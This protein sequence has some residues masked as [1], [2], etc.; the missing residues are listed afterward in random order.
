MEGTKRKSNN[1]LIQGSILAIA[2][3]ISRLIGMV[4]RIPLNNLIENE[5]VGIYSLAFKIYNMCLILSCYSIPTAVSRLVAAKLE[6]KEHKNAYRV[7]VCAMIFSVAVGFVMALILFFGADFFAQTVVKNPKCAM[8]IRVLAPNIVIFSIM[9]VLRG[10]F[11]G[12]NTM[13]PTSISQIVEQIV[14]AVVSIVAAYCYMMAHSASVDIAAYGAKGGTLGTV[15][16]SLTGMLFLLF[17]LTIYFPTMK[18]QMRRDKTVQVDSSVD[19]FKMIVITIIPIVLSQAV[20]Q[21]SGFLDTVFFHSILAKKG[22]SDALRNTYVGIYSN[23]YELLTNVPIA[24]ATAIGAA[25]VPTLVAAL[26]R[27]DYKEIKRKIHATIKFNMIVAIPSAVGLGVLAKPLITMLFNDKSMDDIN[28]ATM[29]LQVGSIAVVL[30]AL[31]TTTNAI[32]NSLNKLRIPLYHS[33]IALVAH[34]IVVIALLQFTSINLYALV[35]GYIL[36]SL[37]VC[38]LNWIYIKR[39]LGY[40]QEMIKTFVIPFMA[41]VLMGVVTKISYEL[42]KMVFHT[43]GFAVVA[44]IGISVIVYFVLIVVMRSVTEKELR[45]FPKGT[46]LIR[47]LKKIH[48]L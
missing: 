17:I 1:F 46:K 38:A 13:L 47:V 21:V 44:S 24:I 35:F 31:S 18:R 32:L 9:G 41:S 28:L 45:S 27:K 40:H 15:M 29:L 42:V 43:N 2:S 37:I 10:Y 20:Y 30:V 5:G 23:K 4:Y 34:L 11:Q 7:F 22:V 8:P 26:T 48:I 16:G 3:I 39:N 19:T 36:F 14:N 25:V 12:K 33:A 6:K